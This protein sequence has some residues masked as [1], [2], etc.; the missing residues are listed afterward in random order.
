MLHLIFLFTEA[1]NMAEVVFRGIKKAIKILTAFSNALGNAYQ[2]PG[3]CCSLIFGLASSSPCGMGK[4]RRKLEVCKI[5]GT[6][7]G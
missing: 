7:P 3:F 4:M 2:Y 1:G 5:N 6:L